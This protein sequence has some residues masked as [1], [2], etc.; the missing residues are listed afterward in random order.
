[1]ESLVM[2]LLFQKCSEQWCNPK[3]IC[4]F[5][6]WM[7]T[8]SDDPNTASNFWFFPLFF[9]SSGVPDNLSPVMFN[10]SKC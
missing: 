1:M 8:T 9:Q 3:K 7:K 2:S 4:L 5:G 6:V 10:L